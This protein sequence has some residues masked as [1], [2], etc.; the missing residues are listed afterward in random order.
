MCKLKMKGT[1]GR[2]GKVMNLSLSCNWN[3][4]RGVQFRENKLSCIQSMKKSLNPDPQQLD[5]PDLC[6]LTKK[7]PALNWTLWEVF[8]ACFLKWRLYLWFLGNFLE[9]LAEVS[10]FTQK[11]ISSAWQAMEASSVGVCELL[12]PFRTSAYKNYLYAK[13]PP[14]LSKV[15][16]WQT[17]IRIPGYS[18]G[19]LGG[20]VG[21]ASS[22]SS[23]HDLTVRGFMPHVRLCAWTGSRSEPGACF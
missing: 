4:P 16:L 19:C 10:L 9:G 21:W 15:L 14:L 2:R 18:L 12:P 1:V 22:F 13:V 6:P 7:G 20:S 23:C 5:Y 11:P 3:F 8:I 17:H